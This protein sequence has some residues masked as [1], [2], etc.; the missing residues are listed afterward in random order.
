MSPT[1]DEVSRRITDMLRDLQDY[2]NTYKNGKIKD[3]IKNTDFDTDTKHIINN[4]FS[5]TLY[6]EEILIGINSYTI[7]SSTS[8]T[9]SRIFIDW[10]I[11]SVNN[12]NKI[13][14]YQCKADLDIDISV[15]NIIDNIKSTIMIES[16][17]FCKILHDEKIKNKNM[18]E[19]IKR[20][21]K[22]TITDA[23]VVA[24]NL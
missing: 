15:D 16:K 18:N 4:S 13:S 19:L 23:D 24:S 10:T 8:Y 6:N 9:P 3:K 21:E 11:A 2:D 20:L 14:N 5:L 1:S 17:R 7:M 22:I 12:N